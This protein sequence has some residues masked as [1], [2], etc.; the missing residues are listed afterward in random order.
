[1]KI[2]KFGTH[3]R[4]NFLRAVGLGTSFVPLCRVAFSQ[5]VRGVVVDR[6]GAAVA[7]CEVALYRNLNEQRPAYTAVANDGGT[8]YFVNPQQGPYTAVVRFRTL[9]ANVPVRV[10]SDGL[11][12]STLVVSW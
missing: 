5:Q 11:H 10:E 9:Q 3:N 2:L 4:R 1:M 12:P 8:F 7:R 6:S